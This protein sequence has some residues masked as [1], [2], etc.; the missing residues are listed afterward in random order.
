MRNGPQKTQ[1]PQLN[2]AYINQLRSVLHSNNAMAYL[3]QVMTQNPRIKQIFTMMQNSNN[4]QAMF[5]SLARE[6][7][8]DPN[9]ILNKLIN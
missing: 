6:V 8:V 2:E 9:Y 1:Q 5:E 7:G 4:Q 3:A